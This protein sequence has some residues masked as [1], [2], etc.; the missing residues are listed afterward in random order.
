MARALNGVVYAKASKLRLRILLRLVHVRYTTLRVSLMN[1][2]MSCMP[3]SSKYP[4]RFGDYALPPRPSSVCQFCWE[5]P[6]AAHLGLFYAPEEIRSL[7]SW[8]YKKLLDTRGYTYITSWARSASGAAAG[9]VWCQLLLPIHARLSVDLGLK[10]PLMG[11]KIEVGCC[12]AVG[13]AIF[14]TNTQMIIIT[15]HRTHESLFEG[16]V[17]STRGEYSTAF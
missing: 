2:A 13:A 4:L 3:F 14:P 15:L 16:Y 10:S 1:P 11:I 7:R 17:H 9:C 5:H 12:E 8:E 6:F